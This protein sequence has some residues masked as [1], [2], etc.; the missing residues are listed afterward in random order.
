[1]VAVVEASA[2]AHLVE[3]EDLSREAV[4]VEVTAAVDG[5]STRTRRTPS[6]HPTRRPISPTNLPLTTKMTFPT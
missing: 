5:A 1:M 4:T 6:K 2:E 3:E